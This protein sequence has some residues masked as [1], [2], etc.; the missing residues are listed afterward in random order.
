MEGRG[1]R[2]DDDDDCDNGDD[3]E[4]SLFLQP[5]TFIQSWLANDIHA[6]RYE[7]FVFAEKRSFVFDRLKYWTR[8]SWITW[9]NP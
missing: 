8:K 6:V 9:I 4:S 7:D 2:F 3:G 1:Q 5:V